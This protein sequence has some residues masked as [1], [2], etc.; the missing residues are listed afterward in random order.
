[1]IKLF[2]AYKFY[3]SF[4]KGES[5]KFANSDI[6]WDTETQERG[7]HY[8]PLSPR[9]T[10]KFVHSPPHFLLYSGR[11]MK[12]LVPKCLKNCSL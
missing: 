12:R 1:M 6:T 4:L 3:H 10:Y 7:S 9:P 2:T 5:L 8:Y 11:K